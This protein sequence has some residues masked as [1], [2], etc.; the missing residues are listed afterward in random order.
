MHSIVQSSQAEQDL[1][2]IWVYTAEEW[3]LAQADSYLE[4][5]VSGIDRLREHPMIG[6]SRDDLRK[7]YRALTVSQ[8]LVF[9]KVSED[10]V[11]IIRVL[12]KSVDSPR[13]L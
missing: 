11:Q 6:A 3:S 8:H 4:E 13:H 2:D 10:E 12:H 9:Y 5:L 7:D 1:I